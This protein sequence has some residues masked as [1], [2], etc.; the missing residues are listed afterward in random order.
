MANK[1]SKEELQERMFS[2][3]D[4]QIV[5]V[6]DPKYYNLGF[7]RGSLKIPLDQLDARVDELDK[8]KEVVVYCASVD[9][10][11]SRKAAEKLEAKGYQV[12]A[13]EGGIKEWKAAGMATEELDQAA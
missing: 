8:N 10:P 2:N 7:I 12:K 4:L 13:Y 11:A 5:N 3:P 9:C 1:I 6:L